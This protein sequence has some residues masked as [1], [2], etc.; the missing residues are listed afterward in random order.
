MPPIL[1]RLSSALNSGIGT[2][3]AI[4][5]YLWYVTKPES[6]EDPSNDSSEGDMQNAPCQLAL[7]YRPWHLDR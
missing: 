7:T 3:H 2:L 4:K 6:L 5:E 1:H